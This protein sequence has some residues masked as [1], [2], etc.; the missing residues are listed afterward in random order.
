[1]NDRVFTFLGGDRRTAW[2]KAYL[3]SRGCTVS[4]SICPETTHFILPYPAFDGGHIR[5]GPEIGT[6]LD[7]AGPGVSVFGGQIGPYQE[8]LAGTGACIRDYSRDE[9]FLWANAAIT[10]EAAQVMLMQEL[11]GCLSCCRVLITGFGRIGKLLALR[12]LREGCSV[13]AAA[14]GERD[15]AMAEALGC[16]ANPIGKYQAP[17]RFDAIVNTV[18]AQVFSAED[19]ESIAPQAV[20]LELASSPGGFPAHHRRTIIRGGALPGKYAPKDA[21]IALGEVILRVAGGTDA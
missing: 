21:G 20:I 7:A 8:A 4:D 19:M 14:R 15:R 5:G 16:H 9:G 12:L 13:T 11:P 6:L 1:M 2:A 17:D 18:P 10:A 3:Q